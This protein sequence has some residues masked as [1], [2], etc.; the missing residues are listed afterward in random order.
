[1]DWLNSPPLTIQ[2][3]KGKVVVIDFWTYSCINCLRSIPYV[4]AWA[5]KYEDHGLVVI[6]VHT[7]EFAFE[8]NINNVRAAVSGLKIEYPVAIDNEYKIWRSSDNK[9]WPADYFHHF[10][11][12]EYEESEQE[13]QRLLKEAGDG[14]VPQ[15]LVTVNASGAEAAARASVTI[16]RTTS[17]HRTASSKTKAMSMRRHHCSSISGAYRAIGRSEVRMRFSTERVAVLCIGF[18]LA[19]CIWS[20]V[21]PQTVNRSDFA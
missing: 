15:S 20:S 11:E 3:L 13:I 19:I 6:G 10:G 21:Q 9:Y 4:K 8:R 18:T 14:N 1:V 16:A 5:K 17:P 7:P 2:G 12:G